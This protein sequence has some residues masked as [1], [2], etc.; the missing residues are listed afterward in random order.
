MLKR[1][2]AFFTVD[3]PFITETLKALRDREPNDV[4][5]MRHLLGSIDLVDM[6]PISNMRPQQRKDFAARIEVAHRDIKRIVNQII[7]DQKEFAFT[8]DGD[9]M[10]TKGTVNGLYLVLDALEEWH[11]EH[12]ENSKP[13]EDFDP[14]AT[15]PELLERI[16]RASGI[17]DPE[18]LKVD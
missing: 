6:Q 2:K 7:V 4:A 3:V 14:H 9:F 8:Q 11:N 12:L 10:F 15:L 5:L 13:R 1:I 17:P 18:T 16:S